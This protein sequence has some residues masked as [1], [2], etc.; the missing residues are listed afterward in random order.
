MLA[1]NCQSLRTNL[2][3][4]ASRRV[5]LA[6][7]SFTSF[8]SLQQLS[9]TST[10]ARQRNKLIK[11]PRLSNNLSVF[12]NGVQEK[13]DKRVIEDDIDF[14]D[15]ELNE[16]DNEDEDE[17]DDD[18]VAVKDGGGVSG[19]FNRPVYGP[20]IDMR[21]RDG[22][23]PISSTKLKVRQHV[24]PLANKYRQPLSLAPDWLSS[25]YEKVDQPF[26]V[27]VG[28]SK[29]TWALQMAQENPHINVLGLEIRRPVVE[30]AL[31]RKERWDLKNVHFLSCNANVDLDNILSSITGRNNRISFISFQFPDPH[32]KNKHKKRR[33]VNADLVHVMAKHLRSGDRLFLQSD[34]EEVEQDMVSHVSS[35]PAF[36]PADQYNVAN[37]ISNPNP[38]SVMTEREMS[39]LSKNLPVYRMLFEKK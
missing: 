31:K 9:P 3:S 10:L 4:L 32:F 23:T 28:C 16:D 13:G 30:Y 1:H 38:V 37:L 39:T 5:P 18:G 33:V 27:D 24:N 2:F 19:G 7:K 14:D 35:S 29:G 6:L 17:D 12:I 25:A 8:S 26:I 34:I 11:S 21:K 15:D 20:N 22:A 36:K